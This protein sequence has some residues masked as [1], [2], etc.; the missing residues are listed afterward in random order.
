VL[1]WDPQGELVSIS[2]FIHY[3]IM[4]LEYVQPTTRLGFVVPE[5]GRHKFA[6]A[7]LQ[8]VISDTTFLAA[9]FLLFPL[10]SM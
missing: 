8:I 4:A 7:I 9:A 10:T 1:S 2:R 6:V 5:S 3:I